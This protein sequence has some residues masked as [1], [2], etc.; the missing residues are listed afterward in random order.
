MKIKGAENGSDY[1]GLLPLPF[2]R[3]ISSFREANTFELKSK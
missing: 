1:N 3:A 2:A